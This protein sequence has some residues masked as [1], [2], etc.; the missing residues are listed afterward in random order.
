MQLA[1]LEG[2]RVEARIVDGDIRAD[3]IRSDEVRLSATTG[4]VVLLGLLR[5]RAHYDLHSY[6]GEV[7]LAVAGAPVGF[8]LRAS[9]PFAIVSAIPLQTLW[10]KGDRMRAVAAAT[11]GRAERGQVLPDVRPVVELGSSLGRVVLEVAAL[12]PPSSR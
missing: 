12:P 6:S 2:T 7:R 5:P 4:A 9:S 11:R 8:D 10:Q 1:D 3:D